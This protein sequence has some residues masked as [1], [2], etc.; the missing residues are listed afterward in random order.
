MKA[1]AMAPALTRR[2]SPPREML[3]EVDLKIVKVS[4][5]DTSVSMSGL[6]VVTKS[7]P[8]P[9]TKITVLNIRALF[10]RVSKP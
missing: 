5:S 7:I 4:G 6:K 1:R 8:N 3:P 2:K 9:T 10:A